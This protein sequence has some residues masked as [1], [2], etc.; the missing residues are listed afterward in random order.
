MNFKLMKCNKILEWDVIGE[1]G[2]NELTPS[3]REK[4]RNSN[5]AQS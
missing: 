5:S 2:W 1:E 4:I 3:I